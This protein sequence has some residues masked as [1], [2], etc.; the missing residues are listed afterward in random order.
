[1]DAPF[2]EDGV[3]L[4]R[5]ERSGGGGLT[6]LALQ[7]VESA[8]TKNHQGSSGDVAGIAKLVGHISWNHDYGTGCGHEPLVAGLHLVGAFEDVIKLFVAIM[9]VPRHALAR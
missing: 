8:G 4:L 1:M 9:D 6:D 5:V 2:G 3:A 7:F